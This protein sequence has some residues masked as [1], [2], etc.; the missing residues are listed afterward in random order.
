MNI[1]PETL[2]RNICTQAR[3]TFQSDVTFLKTISLYSLLKTSIIKKTATNWI[4]TVIA[5]A[6]MK[7][8]NHYTNMALQH[9]VM[10]V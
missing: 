3:C 5:A 2:I 6:T 8:T 10:D 7:S 4:Q 1:E 9:R